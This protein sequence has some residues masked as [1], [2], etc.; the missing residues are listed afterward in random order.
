MTRTHPRKPGV[1]RLRNNTSGLTPS[2]RTKETPKK[3]QRN[4]KQAQVLCTHD[5]QRPEL[6]RRSQADM[7]A[8]VARLHGG[9][10]R[11][12]CNTILSKQS[13]KSQRAIANY[14]HKQTNASTSIPTSHLRR[15]QRRT[16]SQRHSVTPAT[17]IR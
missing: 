8:G 13:R 7:A 9:G 5:G 16:A 6:G 17:P 4:Q 2:R 1:V 14:H 12:V 11:L 10:K 15:E 3:H